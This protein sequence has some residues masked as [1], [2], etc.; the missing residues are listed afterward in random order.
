MT[1]DRRYTTVVADP[2]W[3]YKEPGQFVKPRS[4]LNCASAAARYPTMGLAEICEL[5]VY[6]LLADNAH[7]Y[8]WT[9]NS[10]MRE[11]YDVAAAWGF[12]PKTIL[13]WVKTCKGGEPRRPSMRM[14][15]YYRSATEHVLFCVRGSLRLTGPAAPT[16]F[17]FPRLAHSVKPDGF[18]DMVEAQSP[19]PYLEMFA[20]R[21]RPGWDA[22]GNEIGAATIVLPGAA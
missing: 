1:T 2:P 18:L 15:Y 5:P 12:R 20:R 9:T 11:A 17:H 7:L 21:T 8:L 3:R 6:R 4:P 14:G 13:T 16:A 22:F 19:G 10:F